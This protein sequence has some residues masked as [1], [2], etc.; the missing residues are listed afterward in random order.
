[1][2][3]RKYRFLNAKLFPTKNTES[4]SSSYEQLVMISDKTQFD[5]RGKIYTAKLNNGVY[6]YTKSWTDTTGTYFDKLNN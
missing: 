6:Q 4:C 5:F 2:D 1:M 3:E